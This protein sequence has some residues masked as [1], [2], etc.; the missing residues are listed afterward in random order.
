MKVT[1]GLCGATNVAFGIGEACR[2]A[3]C[4]GTYIEAASYEAEIS[5][6]KKWLTLTI[7]MKDMEGNVYKIY[8]FSVHPDEPV[9]ELIYRIQETFSL[10]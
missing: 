1:C 4:G 5:K 9:T 2:Q 8:S 10:D 7:P 6:P 3:L